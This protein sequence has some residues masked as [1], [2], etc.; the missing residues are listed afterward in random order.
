LPDNAD[1]AKVKPN[2]KLQATFGT[3]HFKT[4]GKPLVDICESAFSGKAALQLTAFQTL[5]S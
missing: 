3:N 1:I 5:N 4:H 2:S